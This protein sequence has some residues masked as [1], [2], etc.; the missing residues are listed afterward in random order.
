MWFIRGRFHSLEE[1]CIRSETEREGV[2]GR[3]R[4]GEGL[5]PFKVGIQGEFQISK[6]SL[7]DTDQHAP[8]CTTSLHLT[9]PFHN[10]E[11]VLGIGDDKKSN[12]FSIYTVEDYISCI[13]VN[14]TPDCTVL[15]LDSK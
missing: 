12:E 1:G 4:L 8:C 3:E 6:P 5:S 14:L 15:I 9:T 13:W 2:E 7:E 11:A 10:H